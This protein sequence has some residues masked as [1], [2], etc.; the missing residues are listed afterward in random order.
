MT[1]VKKESR[2]DIFFF[3]KKRSE[4]VYYFQFWS[5]HADNHINF[6]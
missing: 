5:F 4:I 3:K 2:V 1:K 6:F